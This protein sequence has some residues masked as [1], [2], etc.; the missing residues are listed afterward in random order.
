MRRPPGACV[1][2]AVVGHGAVTVGPC[3]LASIIMMVDGA[4]HRPVAII[5]IGARWHATL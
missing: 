1:A 3:W 4:Q 2:P 5:M